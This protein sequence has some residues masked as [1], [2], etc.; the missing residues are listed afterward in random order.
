MSTQHDADEQWRFAASCNPN[1]R[2]NDVFKMPRYWSDE[3]GLPNVGPL[4]GDYP[5]SKE[6][7]LRRQTRWDENH[8]RLT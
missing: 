4:W 5:I 2:E 3:L 7:F 6:E 8:N 1:Q